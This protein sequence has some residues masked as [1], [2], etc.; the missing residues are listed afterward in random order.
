MLLGDEH[1]HAWISGAQ[2][3][4]LDLSASWGAVGSPSGG[5]AVVQFVQGEKSV[6]KG[7]FSPQS[8]SSVSSDAPGA[9]PM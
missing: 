2:R 5:G 4:S 7:Q 8:H 6:C 9:E 3:L 1:I